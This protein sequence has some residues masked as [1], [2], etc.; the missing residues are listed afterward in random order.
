MEYTQ[1]G[2]GLL[3]T[4]IYLIFIVAWIV[5]SVIGF[6]KTF[7]KAGK[8]GWWSLV[9]FLNTYCMYDIAFGNGWL[10][11][12]LLVPIVN[13]VISVMFAIKFAKAFGKSVGF[14]IA[15]IL[16]APIMICILGFGSAQYIGVENN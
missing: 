7:E 5:I 8:P 4:G 13:I 11:L 16:F 1:N 2:V 6:W 14:G 12:L 10:F 9:P 3:F 15:I